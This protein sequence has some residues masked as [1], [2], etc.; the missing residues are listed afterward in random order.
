MK[1]NKI[2]FEYRSYNNKQV[3]KKG[4][5]TSLGCCF[6][7]NEFNYSLNNSKLK[8]YRRF[9]YTEP[10]SVHKK[11]SLHKIIQIKRY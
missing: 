6:R 1:T 2:F 3:N 7:K 8:P 9:G 10:S 11:F 4:Q 5:Q